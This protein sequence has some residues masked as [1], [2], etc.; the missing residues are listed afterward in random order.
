MPNIYPPLSPFSLYMGAGVRKKAAMNRRTPKR[1]IVAFVKDGGYRGMDDLFFIAYCVL[2]VWAVLQAALGCLQTWEHRRFVRS[3]IKHLED[4]R[5][6][7]K[8]MI[9]APCK[10]VDLDLRRN[11]KRLFQQDYEDYE[12]TF[13]VQSPSDPC[14]KLIE[15][16]M[17]ENGHIRSRLVIAGRVDASAEKAGGQKVHNLLVATENFPADVEYLVFVDSD[18]QPRREWL[19]AIIGRLGPRMKTGEVGASTGYRWMVPV[20]ASLANHILYSINCGVTIL[21]GTQSPRTVWGGSWAIRRDTFQEL[22]IRRNWEGT[23][24]DDFVAGAVLKS[25]GRVIKYEPGCLVPS[26]VDAGMLDMLSFLRRQYLIARCHVP[27]WWLL[28]LGVSLIGNIIWP[29]SAAAIIY[30]AVCGLPVWPPAAVL[31]VVYGLGTY[32]GMVRQSLVKIYFPHLQDKLRAAS[33][34]DIWAWPVASFAH[35]CALIS[36]AFGRKITWRNITYILHNGGRAEIVL[37]DAMKLK[38]FGSGAEDD[39]NETETLVAESEREKPMAA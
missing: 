39:L 31:A 11:L 8:A 1:K 28:G 2:A 35:L 16:A 7:G 4:Y 9:F 13:I 12:I 36:S 18:A 38:A 19:R 24:S 37:T 10:G 6:R 33:R 21:L 34:F 32:R 20:R 22:D 3:R 14:C 30:A 23:L 26:P 15:R 17:A 5:P 29:A 27:H 25:Q